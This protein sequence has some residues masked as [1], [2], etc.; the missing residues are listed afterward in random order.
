MKSEQEIERRLDRVMKRAKWSMKQDD[1]M[2][3][4]HWFSWTEAL[5]WVL[6]IE[7]EEEKANK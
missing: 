4:E 2:S 1:T 6:G 3:Y 7:E 5:K